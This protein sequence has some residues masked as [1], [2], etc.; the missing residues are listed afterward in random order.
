M[1]KKSPILVVIFLIFC[2]SANF[3]VRHVFFSPTDS[4][5]STYSH[6]LLVNIQWLLDLL[7]RKIL[8]TGDTGD[9]PDAGEGQFSPCP[10]LLSTG[11]WLAAILLPAH[12]CPSQ[13]PFVA[14]YLDPAVTVSGP[15]GAFQ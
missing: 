5:R 12:S 13:A 3:K 8:H 2:D 9:L 7:K 10:Q 4:G 14:I 1:G 15:S 6:Q 11:C